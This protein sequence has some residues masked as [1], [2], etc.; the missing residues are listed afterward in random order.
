MPRLHRARGAFTLIELLVVIAIIGI[1]IGL[2]L[3]A[4]Q[5]VRRRAAK[6]QCGS[7]MHNVSLAL[8]MYCD[9]N[10]GFPVA[11]EL[12]SLE[13][14]TPRLDQVLYNFV[15]KDT[16]VFRCPMDITRF[17]VEHLSYEYPS[18]QI[19]R[20]TMVQLTN[21]RFGTTGTLVLYDFDPIHGPLGSTVSR[22]YLY[23]DGHIE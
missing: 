16:R 8:T 13:P 6:I 15:D 9:V 17:D 1:L 12:P 5:Q 22:N 10:N 21:S 20:K 23:A 7:N 2:L 4:V 18:P 19:Q 11:A 3:P 14:N